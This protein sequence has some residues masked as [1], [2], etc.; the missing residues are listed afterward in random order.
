MR[1]WR[2][3]W[4]CAGRVHS[5][6]EAIILHLPDAQGPG[7]YRLLPAEHVCR[8]AAAAHD[9]AI[10]HRGERQGSP[11]HDGRHGSGPL[12]GADPRNHHRPDAGGLQPHVARGRAAGH[13]VLRRERGLGRAWVRPIPPHQHHDVHSNGRDHVHIGFCDLRCL[14][15]G[16]GCLPWGGRQKRPRQ[17]PRSCRRTH[18]CND[19]RPRLRDGMLPHARPVGR[20]HRL[21]ERHVD[22]VASGVRLRPLCVGRGERRLLWT[23]C[24]ARRVVDDGGG[25]QP[26]GS[27]QY[28]ACEHLGVLQLLPCRARAVAHLARGAAAGSG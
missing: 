2:S 18:I 15:L 5:G 24:R 3:G 21:P 8:S 22:A 28:S 17:A 19:V 7:R 27:L 23:R 25:G 6:S 1:E 12:R 13:R 26:V 10:L 4:M 9:P 14:E 11:F 20:D 16:C